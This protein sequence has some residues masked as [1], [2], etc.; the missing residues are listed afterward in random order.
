MTCT[1]NFGRH[2]QPA[3]CIRRWQISARRLLQ[4]QQL[5]A[6]GLSGLASGILKCANVLKRLQ[7]PSR[8][9]LPASGRANCLLG[10]LSQPPSP[11]KKTAWEQDGAAQRR[12]RHLQCYSTPCPLP[13]W[14]AILFAE[15]HHLSSEDPALR[16]SS[17][18]RPQSSFSKNKENPSPCPRP[19]AALLFA[20][21]V[22][23]C[24]PN[25]NMRND[26]K[27]H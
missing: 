3:A 21:K 2:K 13:Q 11:E 12:T 7:K 26:R 24:S 10:R 16:R 15:L 8:A 6:M 19:K 25:G 27:G 22:Q 5:Q 9:R 18:P 20:Q 4:A 1:T 17:Q 23:N 14:G